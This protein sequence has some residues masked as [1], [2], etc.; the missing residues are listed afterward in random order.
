MMRLKFLKT[1]LHLKRGFLDHDTLVEWLFLA[2][3]SFHQERVINVFNPCHNNVC[4]FRNLAA[5]R[6]T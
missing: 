3:C 2:L 5:Y 6:S 4:L 1:R